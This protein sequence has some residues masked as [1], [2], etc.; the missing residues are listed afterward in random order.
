MAKAQTATHG[1]RVSLDSDV[2]SGHIS[3]QRII[4]ELQIAE[5][6]AS[7]VGAKWLTHEEVFAP[8]RKKYGYEVHS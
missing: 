2:S 1:D 7:A 3:D 8:L 5:R 6:E 4:A